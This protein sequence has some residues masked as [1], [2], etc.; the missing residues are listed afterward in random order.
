MARKAK[1]TGGE[2]VKIGN[3]PIYA[4]QEVSISDA[5]WA[6]LPAAIQDMFSFPRGDSGS[7]SHALVGSDH[8]ASGLTAGHVLKATGPTGFTFGQLTASDMFDNNAVLTMLGIPVY[9][10]G[11]YYS[12]IRGT[13]SGQ[14]PVVNTM[15]A[16]P[17]PIA[18]KNFP[19]IDR[20]G[21]EITGAGNAGSYFTLGAIADDP[22]YG[23]F[24]KG[25]VIF[26]T[27]VKYGAT[28]NGTVVT[29]P[30]IT[31]DELTGYRGMVWLT[32]IALL[33]TH[34]L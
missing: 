1:L 14:T 31:I 21:I 9:R 32:L 22:A 27:E 4:G 33:R 18:Q 11:S 29:K 8:S 16:S 6:A 12:A 28:I 19:G 2:Y 25:G 15:Y 7:S 23:M 34:P 10:G 13:D 24:P 5:D 3:T 30:E 17:F 26:D 20:I